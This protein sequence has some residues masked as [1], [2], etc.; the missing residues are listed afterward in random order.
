MMYITF[1]GVRYE[2]PYN[3]HTKIGIGDRFHFDN[4]GFR[5]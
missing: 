4:F 5:L 2:V 1:K 3:R